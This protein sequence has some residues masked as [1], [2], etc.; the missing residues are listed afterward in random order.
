MKIGVRKTILTYSNYF[1]A[2]WGKQEGIIDTPLQNRS[3]NFF[4]ALSVNSMR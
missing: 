2:V 4:I 3:Y 1:F